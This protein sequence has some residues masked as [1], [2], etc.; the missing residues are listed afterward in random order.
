[1]LKSDRSFEVVHYLRGEGRLVHSLHV[2]KLK[3]VLLMVRL[4][5][6]D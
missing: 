3:Q 6:L 2:L 5:R 4:I 1:M